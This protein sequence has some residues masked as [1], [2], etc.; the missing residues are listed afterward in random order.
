MLSK[1]RQRMQMIGI[2]AAHTNQRCRLDRQSMIKVIFK[3]APFIARNNGM[4]AI[5]AF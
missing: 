2:R 5:I 3:F 1:I 4:Q